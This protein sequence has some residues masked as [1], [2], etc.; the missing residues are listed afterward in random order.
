MTCV[1]NALDNVDARVYMDNLCIKYTKP[2]IESGTLGSKGNTQTIIPYMTE[3]YGSMVDPPEKSIPVCTLKNFPYMIE[4]TIIYARDYLE[5]V[6]VT[7]PEKINTFL[8]KKDTYLDTLSVTEMNEL[9]HDINDVINT[10]PYTYSDCIT[11]AID[12]WYKLFN[13]MIRDIITQ[14]PEDSVNDMGVLFWQGTK[15]F[16]Q[17][18]DFDI[19]NTND[20]NFITSIAQLRAYT[21]NIIIINYTKVEK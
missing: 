6:I 19:E 18:R 16:P 3:T 20:Y 17:Y 1:M 11:Y 15:K 21:Y 4:H 9:Y 2:L 5:G 13:H 8:N 10:M 14:Y 7:L 12:M